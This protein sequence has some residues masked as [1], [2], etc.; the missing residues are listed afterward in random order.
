MVLDRPAQRVRAVAEEPVRILYTAT[1]GRR[2]FWCFAIA[3]ATTQGAP[4]RLTWNCRHLANATMR[5]LI[6][7]VCAG[8]GLMAPIICTPEELLE[9]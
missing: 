5:P 4:Y 7:A 2:A 9:T 8:Q 1:G 6:E 3:V